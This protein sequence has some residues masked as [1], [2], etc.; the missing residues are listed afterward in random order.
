MDN[1]SRE[2]EE[3]LFNIIRT[4]DGEEDDPSQFL[5]DSG[6]GLE[7]EPI[8]EGQTNNDGKENVGSVTKSGEVY[9]KPLGDH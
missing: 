2:N 1:F 5:N 4:N 6:D 8:D 7:L 3:D 9:I